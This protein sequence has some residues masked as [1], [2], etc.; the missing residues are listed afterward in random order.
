M[1]QSNYDRKKKEE[2]IEAKDE[3]RL[4]KAYDCL[5]VKACRE[6][7]NKF[8]YFLQQAENIQKQAEDIKDIR[9]A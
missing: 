2:G 4:D 3:A 7:Y 9:F 6:Q 8:G 5:S 1:V